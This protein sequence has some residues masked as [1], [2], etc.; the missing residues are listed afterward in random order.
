MNSGSQT[1]ARLT[2]KELGAR[3][4]KIIDT[5]IR[6]RILTNDAV[7]QL[8]LS[9]AN[10][11]ATIKVT[12]RLVKS[13]WLKSS[14]LVGRRQYF[15]PGVKTIRSFGLPACRSRPLGPQ[16]LATQLALV[17][18][19]ATTRPTLRILTENEIIA[20]VANA[21]KQQRALQHALENGTE[22]GPMRLLRVDLGGSPVHVAKK[23]ETDIRIRVGHPYYS[24]MLAQRRLIVV[25]LTTTDLKKTLVETAIAKRKWPKG[26]RFNVT[27]V[28]ILGSLLGGR[29]VD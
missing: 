13:G 20:L 6:L 14:E 8:F 10:A 17:E 2:R 4:R 12:G 21:T 16:A 25:V 11:N 5:V 1:K 27:V 28:P 26:V 19:V 22:E 9:E 23:L 3:D 24:N 18:Y 29:Y 15:L 7:E